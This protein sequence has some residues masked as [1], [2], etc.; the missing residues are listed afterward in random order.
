MQDRGQST[1]DR[2]LNT[3]SALGRIEEKMTALEHQIVDLK[4]QLKD[5]NEHITAQFVTKVEFA[6]IKALVFGLVGLIL[7]S[8][9]G[10]LLMLVVKK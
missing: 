10:A 7:L 5:M 1:S 3:A 4:T 9:V 8:V 2:D 6:P